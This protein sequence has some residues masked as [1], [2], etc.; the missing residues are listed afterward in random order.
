M[1]G[2]ARLPRDAQLRGRI[3]VERLHEMFPE[4][5]RRDARMYLHFATTTFGATHE[6]QL[7]HHLKVC[8]TLGDCLVW[9]DEFGIEDVLVLVPPGVL[10]KRYDDHIDWAEESHRYST[11]AEPQCNRLVRLS[12]DRIEEPT[13]TCSRQ[14]K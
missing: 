13:Q 6:H 7:K 2:P 1:E 8:E 4:Q 12:V 5:E 10:W 3:A 9:N 11:D 14:E